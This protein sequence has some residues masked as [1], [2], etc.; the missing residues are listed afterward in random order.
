MTAIAV[1]SITPAGLPGPFG[2]RR[3][4]PRFAS[5]PITVRVLSGIYSVPGQL[6]DISKSGMRLRVSIPM[7]E[8]AEATIS[9]SNIVAAGEVRYCQPAG[10]KSFDIGILLQDV[11]HTA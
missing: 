6:L 1:P 8:R 5:G 11:L 10:D 9:F 2:E 4:E 7:M 3:T